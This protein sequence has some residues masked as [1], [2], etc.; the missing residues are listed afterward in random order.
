MRAKIASLVEKHAEE[1]LKQ[2]EEKWD[3]MIKQNDLKLEEAKA[4]IE[5]I[6]QDGI[7]GSAKKALQLRRAMSVRVRCGTSRQK[8]ENLAETFIHLEN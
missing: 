8:F 4:E 3:A 6:H 2:E 1:R 7:G 5:K